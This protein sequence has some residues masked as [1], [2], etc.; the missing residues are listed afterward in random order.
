MTRYLIGFALMCVAGL[1]VQDRMSFA[2]PQADEG[3]RQKLLD[4]R[5]NA[6]KQR[7]D[8]AVARLE[9]GETVA[10]ETVLAARSDYVESVL[11][12][13]LDRKKRSAILLEQFRA[14]QDIEKLAIKAFELGDLNADARYL[15]T[16]KRIEAELA[17]VDSSK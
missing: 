6:Y 13:M 4:K 2:G 16:A 11:D 15:A 7:L 9:N 14:A 12:L 5:C 10:L 8:H 3:I 17:L 1:I